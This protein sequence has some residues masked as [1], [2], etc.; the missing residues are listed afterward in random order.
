M[1]NVGI[2]LLN[3][4]KNELLPIVFEINNAHDYNLM[5]SVDFSKFQVAVCVW[6]W[7]S[8][9][10]PYGE[11]IICLELKEIDGKIEVNKGYSCWRP[12][13]VETYADLIS[14]LKKYLTKAM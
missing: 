1:G 9:E 10:K 8:A 11:T 2:N 4:V 6:V 13:S 14:E 3:A 7:S 5:A 12:K